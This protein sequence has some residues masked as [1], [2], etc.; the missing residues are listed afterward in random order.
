LERELQDMERKRKEV[1]QRKEK[2]QKQ[3]DEVIRNV[4]M[5]SKGGGVLG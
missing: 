2:L 3:L 5:N 4:A 1:V